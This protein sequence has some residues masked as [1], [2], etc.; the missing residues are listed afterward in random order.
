LIIIQWILFYIIN[1]P[2]Y[3]REIHVEKVNLILVVIVN[4]FIVAIVNLVLVV[5]VNLFLVRKRNK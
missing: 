2:I 4:L 1:K 3:R 5:I